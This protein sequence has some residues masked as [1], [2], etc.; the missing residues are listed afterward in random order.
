MRFVA[1]L[2]RSVFAWNHG[3]VMGWDGEGLARRLGAA[4]SPSAPRSGV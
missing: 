4:R 2:A 3:V 1:P